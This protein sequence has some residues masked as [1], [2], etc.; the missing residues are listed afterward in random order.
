MREMQK[1]S[2][3]FFS[4]PNGSNFALKAQSYEKLSAE[5]KNPFFFVLSNFFVDLIFVGNIEIGAGQ[6]RKEVNEEQRHVADDEEL[7]TVRG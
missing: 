2:L 3:L 5:Q 7:S 1:E 6:E 4:F